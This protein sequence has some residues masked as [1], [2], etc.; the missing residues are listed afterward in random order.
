MT[1]VFYADDTS[2][3]KPKPDD[4]KL[5]ALFNRIDSRNDNKIS[6]EKFASYIKNKQ[7]EG[8]FLEK[9]ERKALKG[10]ERFVAA[11]T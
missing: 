11:L 10:K 6:K 5:K 1:H 2:D 4:A 7:P 9:L 8:T 3:K